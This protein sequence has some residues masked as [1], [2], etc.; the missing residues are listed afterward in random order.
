MKLVSGTNFGADKI[1]LIRLYTSL[2]CQAYASAAKTHLKN[3]TIQATAPRIATGAHKGTQTFSLEVKCNVLPL[4]KRRDEM[5]LKYWAHSASL[6]SKLPI[7]SLTEPK[8]IY[9]TCRNRF[10]GRTLYNIKVQDLLKKNTLKEIVIQ[11][12]TFP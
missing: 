8:S 5:T 12:Q 7:H 6:G 4:Q 2:I 10:H 9:T 1:I 3:D 11:K